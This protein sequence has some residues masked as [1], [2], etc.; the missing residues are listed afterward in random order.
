MQRVPGLR[1]RGERL[2]Q[3]VNLHLAPGGRFQPAQE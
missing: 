1:L 2:V 3:R